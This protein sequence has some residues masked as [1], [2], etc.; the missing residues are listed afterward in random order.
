MQIHFILIFVCFIA[1]S[2]GEKANEIRPLLVRTSQKYY[3]VA[4]FN[5]KHHGIEI[6][7]N[8]YLQRFS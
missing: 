3:I 6:V 5:F 4:V 2:V 1:I 7:T 8:C